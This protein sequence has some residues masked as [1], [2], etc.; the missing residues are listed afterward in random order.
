MNDGVFPNVV[1]GRHAMKNDFVKA[2]VDSYIEKGRERN[3]INEYAFALGAVE[4]RLFSILS[5]LKYMNPEIYNKII[6][7]N[8]WGA[9]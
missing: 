1:H 9:E 5:R 3:C 6:E 7:E 8:E 4:S 2:F